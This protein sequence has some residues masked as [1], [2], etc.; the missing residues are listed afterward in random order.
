M[1]AA[2][3]G[4]IVDARDTCFVG[5]A[6]VDLLPECNALSLAS[7]SGQVVVYLHLAPGSLRVAAGAVVRRGDVL[8]AAGNTG[9][10]TGAHLHVQLNA[11]GAGAEASTV[12]WALEDAVCGAVLPVAGHWYSRAGWQVPVPALERLRGALG[13]AGAAAGAA[14]GD[15]AAAGGAPDLAPSGALDCAREGLLWLRPEPF[16]APP[17]DAAAHAEQSR[18]TAE[19]CFPSLH[20]CLLAN[21]VAVCSLLREGAASRFVARRSLPPVYLSCAMNF[22]RDAAG[23][24]YSAEIAIADHQEGAA[25][26]AAA[27]AEARFAF[28]PA[29]GT[30]WL[31]YF[32]REFVLVRQYELWNGDAF[33]G[34]VDAPPVPLPRNVAAFPVYSL[35]RTTLAGFAQEALLLLRA[36]GGRGGGAV[37]VYRSLPPDVEPFGMWLAW[38]VIAGKLVIIDLQNGVVSE[39]LAAAIAALAWDEPPRDEVFFV[40]FA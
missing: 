28:D 35:R 40:P 10:S 36:S 8:A 20:T 30:D 15:G 26:E 2:C 5:G 11:D 13:F 29:A 37:V 12:M 3:D 24:L 7:P 18:E 1:L 25:A 4:T 22:E 33:C 6:H 19:R 16:V 38:F 27:H 23:V 17:E 34:N 32:R 21:V 31:T 39:G 9:F 14:G